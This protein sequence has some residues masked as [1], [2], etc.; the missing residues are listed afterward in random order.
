MRSDVFSFGVVLYELL[1]KKHPFRKDTLAGTL[2]AI[3]EE[4]PAH[5]ESLTRGVAPAVGGIVRRCLEK[6]REDRYASGRDVAVALETVLAAPSG[7]AAL[8]EVEERSPYPGLHSF[9]EK[10]TAVFF[11]REREVEDLWRRLRHRRLLAVIGPSGVGKTSFVRAGI[12]PSC[13]DGWGVL[14]CTPGTAPMAGLGR[15]LAPELASDPEA[16]QELPRFEDPQVAFELV[17][18][19]R[20]GQGEALLVVDQLEEL[21]TLNPPEVQER[22]AG[23]LARLA[24]EAD[25][26]VLLSLRD[27]FLMRCHDHEPLIP[28][29]TELT[30][31]GALSVPALERALREPAKKL[32]YRFE[33]QALVDE[34]VQSVEGA[35]AALPL[36]A[37]AVS[38]LW[39][40][41]DREE[42]VLTRAA[43]EEIGGVGG[44][45]A[46]HAETTMDRIGAERQGMVR[47][48]FRNLVTAQWTRA[49]ISREE[50]LSAFPDRQSAET[51]LG[52]LIDARLLT[53]YEVTEPSPC[54]PEEPRLGQAPLCHPEEPRLRLATRDLLLHRPEPPTA[55]R[56]STSPC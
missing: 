27:D 16:L 11:G 14:V 36:L 9:T 12:V 4:T 41:R 28:V 50:L 48:I 17:S 42:K 54:H 24:G 46:Q 35:R 21:F 47:E 45:L 33:D 25:V 20:K 34:M 5:L 39:E 51:V 22:F 19:W 56:S 26:H 38:R 3:V 29:F 37:F 49:V 55:S 1:A 40:K 10:D 2:T 30:P 44:A 52:Q 8:R 15:V 13:P 18:R 7:A 43:Y 53:S 32:G 31:L 6:A 23:L